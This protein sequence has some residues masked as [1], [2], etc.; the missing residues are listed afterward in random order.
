MMKKQQAIVTLFL[1]LSVVSLPFA[2]HHNSV[3]DNS[4][5]LSDYS[6]HEMLSLA[7]DNWNQA[8]SSMQTGIVVDL[9][10]GNIATAHGTFDPLTQ[11]SPTFPEHFTNPTDYMLT[12]MKFLQLTDYQSELTEE[13]LLEQGIVILDYLGDASFLIR[14][15]VDQTSAL[16]FLHSE[17]SVRWV[18]NV[19]PGFRVH[20]DLLW[21]AKV[22]FYL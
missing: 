17:N 7:T 22:A 4:S 20:P 10:T 8:S 15:P 6:E 13:K 2:N 16:D 18:G 1:L 19:D 3:T 12:G 11:V 21:T 9:P 14:F 5:N